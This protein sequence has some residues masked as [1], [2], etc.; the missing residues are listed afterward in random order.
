MIVRAGRSVSR[1]EIRQLNNGRDSLLLDKPP[2]EIAK[3]LHRN[4][5]W[6]WYASTN[7]R[8]APIYPDSQPCV[9]GKR[10]SQATALS[11]LRSVG[12]RRQLVDG[13]I[14][15]TIDDPGED[16]GEVAERI[17]IVQLTGLNQ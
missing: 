9:S 17:D 7:H 13:A 10:C 1:M 6:A 15:M 2:N 8:A 5:S 3:H 4:L 14:E 12:P 16:V 11:S